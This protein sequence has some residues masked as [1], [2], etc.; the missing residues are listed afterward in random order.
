MSDPDTAFREAHRQADRFP[1]TRLFIDG[2]MAAAEGGRTYPNVT[3]WTGE[4]I[5][6]AADAGLADLDLAVAAARRAFDETEWSRDHARRLDLM[7]RFHDALVA[8]RDEIGAIA[9]AEAGCTSAQ[10]YTAQRD[11]PIELMG[12]TL[13]LARAYAWDEYRGSGEFFGITSERYVWREAIGVVGAITPWN[14]PLAVNLAKVFPAL[15]AG[16]TVVLKPAPE[17][18]YLGVMLG[19][20]ASDAELPAGVLN[21]VTSSSKAEIGEALVR[22]PRVDLISFTGSTAVGKRIMSVAAEQVKRVFLELGG[23]SASI[24]LDDEKFA[25]N[26]ASGVWVLYH[27]GQ[28]CAHLTRLLVPRARYDEA[29][30]ILTPLF[31][32]FP[33][34]DSASPEQV[35]GPIVSEA[36]RQRVLDHIEAAKREGARV[37]AGGGQPGHLHPGGFFVEPTLIVDVDNAM[38]IA[39]EEVFGP[40]QVLIPYDDDE[41]AIRLANDS[42][43]GLS[44]AVYGADSARVERIARRLRV[45]TLGINGGNYLAG[46]M[47]FG[48]YK[49][50]GI[51]REGGI[52][53][54]E[55]YLETKAV[56]FRSGDAAPP[57]TDRAG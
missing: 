5:G 14:F 1:T 8:R 30:G 54:F 52:E 56:A 7:E 22:D 11:K 55:E 49:Q 46:T 2:A 43:Y 31:R 45:G 4:R 38:R 28:G 37:A 10:L 23:K 29:V 15:C 35:M 53:G 24:I 3:P 25:E 27:A 34:G 9:T 20:A 50:S 48:G 36:Q 19:Q 32:G 6:E 47:P 51:G 41:D 17:T 21:V 26:V 44:G 13:E 12:E 40:V 18:P 57:A 39:R 16:C 33:Y 42:D